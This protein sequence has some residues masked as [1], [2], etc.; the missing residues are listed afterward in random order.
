MHVAQVFGM[1]CV[2]CDMLCVRQNQ[3]CY[4]QQLHMHAAA[5]IGLS[6]ISLE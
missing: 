2:I 1:T 5:A 6:S 3:A 4:K